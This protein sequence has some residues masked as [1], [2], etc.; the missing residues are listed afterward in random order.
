MSL[1]TSLERVLDR[2]EPLSHL[3]SWVWRELADAASSSRHGWNQ[4]SLTT[5]SIDGPTSRMVVLRRADSTARILECHTDRRAAKV[6]QIAEDPRV[7]WMFWDPSSR[8]QLRLAATATVLVDGPEVR[9]AWNA[10]PVPSR[11]AYLSLA[12]PGATVTTEH[13]PSTADRHEDAAGSERGRDHF[14][15]VRTTVHSGEALYLRRGGHVRFAFDD[16]RSFWLV[17]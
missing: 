11:A 16:E 5:I 4:T 3:R 12:T 9:E 17:P 14:C 13:S 10:V 7:A 8:I 2:P 15:V 6:G 1:Q